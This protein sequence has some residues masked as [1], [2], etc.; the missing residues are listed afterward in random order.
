MLRSRQI[1][2]DIYLL[3]ERCCDISFSFLS[4]DIYY[5]NSGKEEKETTGE[6]IPKCFEDIIF[7]NPLSL[8]KLLAK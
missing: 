7:G 2:P 5:I 6:K 4:L 1:T 8:Y 3:R